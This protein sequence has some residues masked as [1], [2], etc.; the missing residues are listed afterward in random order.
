[1]VEEAKDKISKRNSKL[2]SS[3]IYTHILINIRYKCIIYWENKLY[4]EL[5]G[6]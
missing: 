6:L 4:L 2:S 1:M 3:L 5:L